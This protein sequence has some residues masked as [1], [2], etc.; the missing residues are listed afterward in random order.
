MESEDFLVSELQKGSI[1]A[2]EKIYN[3]HSLRIER[4]ARHYLPEKA[5]VDDVV[6][7]VFITLWEKRETLRTQCR[8]INFLLVL[9]RNH[10]ISKLR[11]HKVRLGYSNMK[12][13]EYKL[14]LLNI[15]SLKQLHED[16][17]LN[18]DMDRIIERAIDDLPSKCREVFLKSKVEGF[19]HKEIAEELKISEKTVEKRITLSLQALRLALKQTLGF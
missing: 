12:S 5:E 4:F 7:N 9:T 2:F 8:L 1:N 19:K 14:A 17:L 3:L 13:K 10:C 6:Q 18:F 11:E 16:S 15:Y